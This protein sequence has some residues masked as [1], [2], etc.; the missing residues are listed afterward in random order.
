MPARS[1]LGFA[2]VGSGPLVDSAA[3]DGVADPTAHVPC[4]EL[5][6]DYIMGRCGEITGCSTFHLLVRRDS[7]RCPARISCNETQTPGALLCVINGL[8]VARVACV[9]APT[10]HATTLA[11]RRACIVHSRIVT[12]CKEV[13]LVI[14]SECVTLSS[15]SSNEVA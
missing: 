5:A 9:L 1:V 2:K 12:V 13:L 11:A 10:Q 15:W 3:S 8:R 6:I 4:W 14:F 7:V